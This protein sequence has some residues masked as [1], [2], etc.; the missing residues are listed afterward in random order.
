[1]TVIGPPCGKKVQRGAFWWWRMWDLGIES[2]SKEYK[3]YGIYI[4]E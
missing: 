3:R 4:L 2:S 1:M